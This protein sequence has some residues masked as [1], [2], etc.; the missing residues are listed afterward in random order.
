ML[1]QRLRAVLQMVGNHR[2]LVVLPV[3][4][5]LLGGGYTVATHETTSMEITAWRV[6]MVWPAGQQRPPDE[7]VFD[8]TITRQ[9]LVHDTKHQLDDL[10]RGAMGAMGG[11]VIASPT[12]RY[13]ISFAT[14]G[15]PTEDYAGNLDC[16]T[17]TVTTFGVPM[18]VGGADGTSLYGYNLMTTL[19]KLTGM[20][21][22][23]WWSATLP[24]N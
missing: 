14:F 3:L 5:A 17:W 19:R 7:Q 23:S 6:V 8:T 21:L 11:C 10:E 20:P 15:V 9:P 13:D 2:R 4:L 24:T 16:A 1:R 12:Y 18:T 22:P